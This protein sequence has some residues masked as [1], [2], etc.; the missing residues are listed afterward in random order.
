[1][2]ASRDL[3]FATGG[4]TAVHTNQ[5]LVPFLVLLLPNRHSNVSLFLSFC[6]LQNILSWHVLLTV[7]RVI[8]FSS[9]VLSRHTL[10]APHHLFHQAFSLHQLSS[11][12]LRILAIDIQALENLISPEHFKETLFPQVLVLVFSRCLR[13]LCANFGILGET[14]H[15][16]QA[17]DRFQSALRK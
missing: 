6:I 8:E 15:R 11:T 14:R 12:Q 1:M 9:V 13:W 2:D 4:H 7:L 5:L 10:E 17:S 16:I 3:D